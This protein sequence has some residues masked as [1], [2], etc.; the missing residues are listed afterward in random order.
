MMLRRYHTPVIEEETVD[1]VVE[2]VESVA[3]EEMV[4]EVI[5]TDTPV[6]EEE[7]AKEV[8]ESEGKKAKKKAGK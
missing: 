4:E 5:K 7:T 8:I 6:I 1:E 2:S 3:E